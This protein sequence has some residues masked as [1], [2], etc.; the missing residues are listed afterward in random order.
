MGRFRPLP[1]FARPPVQPGGPPSWQEPMPYGVVVYPQPIPPGAEF[2]PNV[3]DIYCAGGARHRGVSYAMYAGT[4]DHRRLQERTWDPYAAAPLV[5][6]GSLSRNPS[7]DMDDLMRYSDLGDDDNFGA[8]LASLEESEAL[9]DL[10]ESFGLTTEEMIAINAFG[11]DGSDGFGL[12]AV[13]GRRIFNRKK[14]E[15]AGGRPKVTSIF[16]NALEKIEDRLDTAKHKVRNVRENL[17]AK[18]ARVQTQEAVL[19]PRPFHDPPPAPP[20]G[21]S[22]GAVVGI[23]AATLLLG[24]GLG[25]VVSTRS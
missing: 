5:P 4:K 24:A 25:Y 22:T 8:E 10:M 13:A 9:E 7:E 19:L 12:A 11:S 3:R 2:L 6:I 20:P 14:S 17:D 1:P 15:S 21:L 18:E 16:R 23:A